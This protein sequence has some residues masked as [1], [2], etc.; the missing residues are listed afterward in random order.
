[1]LLLAPPAQ[2]REVYLNG[3]RL[4]ANVVIR[5]QK[6][7]GCSVRFD[8]HGNVRITAKGF[9][10]ALSGAEAATET[11]N[12]P[13]D[14]VTKRYWLFASQKN[15]GLV[16]YD[17]EVYLNGAS[18]K[19]IRADDDTVVFEVTKWVRPG[20]NL[21]RV[22]ALRNANGKRTTSPVDVMEVVVGE[23]SMKGAHVS[24]E[25]PLV[26]FQRNA[27]ETEDVTDEFSFNSR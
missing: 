4:D 14:K 3:V 2:A 15:R 6:L 26:T 25:R 5:N 21:V 8:E 22:A 12:E 23:G 7:E 17:I 27:S 19:K 20:K 11:E 13:N 10:I 18:V 9:D 16:P 24:I 1:M